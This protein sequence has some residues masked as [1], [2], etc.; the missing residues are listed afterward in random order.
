MFYAGSANDEVGASRIEKRGDALKGASDAMFCAISGDIPEEPVV[1]RKS[2]HLFEKRLIEKALT[3]SGGKCP[4]TGEEL[5]SEDL[6]A[7]K[8]WG[9]VARPLPAS[10]ATMPGLLKTMESEWDTMTLK[11]HK[12][13]KTLSK[14]RQE[15]AHALYQNDAATRV[16]S[17][18][19]S[20]K[21]ELQTLLNKSYQERGETTVKRK[22]DD[23]DATGIAGGAVGGT[24]GNAAKRR[25]AGDDVMADSRD[26]AEET[27]G[28]EDP[29]LLEETR[30][31][32]IEL[33]SANLRTKRKARK[34][35][36]SLAKVSAFQSYVDVAQST[37]HSQSA[38]SSVLLMDE[39]R[40]AVGALDGSISILNAKSLALE[41]T[42][43][44]GI[45]GA[46]HSISCLAR[47]AGTSTLISGGEDGVVRIWNAD[48][49]HA[50]PKYTVQERSSIVDIALHA[51]GDMLLSCCD[52][53]TWVVRDLEAKKVL[54]TRVGGRFVAAD[55]QLRSG[56][57]HPDGLLFATGCANGVTEMWDIRSM[58]AIGKLS[59][60]GLA[61]EV[62]VSAV[63]MSEN[64]YYM[65]SATN[66]SVVIWDLRKHKIA[67][68]VDIED[69]PQRLS[70]AIDYSGMY[71][72]A[73]SGN[74]HVVFSTKK[75]H[76]VLSE[77]KYGSSGDEAAWR[78]PGVGW[79]ADARAIITG[80]GDGSVH[81]YAV[82]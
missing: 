72:C 27:G 25:K 34:A 62:G 57:M 59:A 77:T 48:G 10:A 33:L 43:D 75:K 69:T 41:E 29:E 60:D 32:E 4:E 81:R 7:V 23:A 9:K 39:E 3:A 55:M 1:S 61:G 71:G 11:I 73:V 70:V 30:V 44:C 58:K 28:Q 19:L 42:R 6:I 15:L 63:S 8:S 40:L 2:G 47:P 67:K 22:I 65:A 5:S 12:I 46:K 35:S 80:H 36:E 26:S 18:L 20:E 21:E 54:S 68:Q 50:Q 17:R 78:R 76:G 82:A 13:K 79:E 56:A 38:C 49:G 52:D 51:G 14:T 66:G 24:K 74:G 37:Q 53:G 45:D 16:I 31:K 64:G